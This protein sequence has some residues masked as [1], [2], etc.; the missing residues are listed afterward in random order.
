[1]FVSIKIQVA[2]AGIC[3]YDIVN[4]MGA[5]DLG[6]VSLRLMTSPLKDIV[7]HTQKLRTLNV[8]FVVYGFKI[9]CEISKLPF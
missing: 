4:K 9:L 7:T 1:M 8:Y 2:E 5:D 6:P 3:L